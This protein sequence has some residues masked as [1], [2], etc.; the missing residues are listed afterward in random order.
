MFPGCTAP[1]LLLCILLPILVVSYMAHGEAS[2]P[3][4]TQYTLSIEKCSCRHIIYACM[5]EQPIAGRLNMKFIL[6][7]KQ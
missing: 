7:S 4:R 5:S 3:A 2:S 6:N 1:L